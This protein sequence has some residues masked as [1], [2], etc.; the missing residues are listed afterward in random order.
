LRIR[1]SCEA[2]WRE[3]VALI[4]P[5]AKAKYFLL[6]GWTGFSD[7]P[8]E[9]GQELDRLSNKEKS[10]LGRAGWRNENSAAARRVRY[11]SERYSTGG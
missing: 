11:N 8:V 4:C 7:L 3:L 5:T 1:P 10:I 2:G 9:A 6:A